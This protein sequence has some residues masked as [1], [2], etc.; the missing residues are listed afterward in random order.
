MEGA[1]AA[2]W[3]TLARSHVAVVAGLNRYCNESIAP[4]TEI[5]IRYGLKR[6]CNGWPTAWASRHIVRRLGLVVPRSMDE[7]CGWVIP[8]TS[9]SWRWFMPIASRAFIRLR[10][11]TWNSGNEGSPLGLDMASSTSKF[12][13]VV[14]TGSDTHTFCTPSEKLESLTPQPNLRARFAL[15]KF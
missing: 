13:S 9:W 5:V 11:N 10:E 8:V 14:G 4:K 3:M 1:R 7:R 6:T 12:S 15:P 2:L